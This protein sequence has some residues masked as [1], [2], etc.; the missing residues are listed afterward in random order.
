MRLDFRSTRR[1]YTLELSED[2][3]GVF[4]LRQCWYGLNNR[5]G[6]VKQQVFLRESDALNEVSRITRTRAKHGYQQQ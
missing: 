2:L 4:I 3:F 5:R 6:G 1:G